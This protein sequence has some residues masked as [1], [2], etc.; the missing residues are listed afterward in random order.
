MYGFC[1]WFRGKYCVLKS[2]CS[3][4]IFLRIARL[5]SMHSL[6]LRLDY[7][8]TKRC[9]SIRRSHCKY[10]S[11]TTQRMKGKK[12]KRSFPCVSQCCD[13]RKSHT[14]KFNSMRCLVRLFALC[15]GSRYSANILS[16]S[17][18]MLIN[19]VGITCNPQISHNSAVYNL[20]F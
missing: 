11:R 3:V 9:V 13:W 1:L 16:T 20:Y 19:R 6:W 18:N 8:S 15:K 10:W 7:I 4:I 5:N 2:T 17:L 12:N 14:R